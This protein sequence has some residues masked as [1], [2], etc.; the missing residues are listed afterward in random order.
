MSTPLEIELVEQAGDWSQF[1]AEALL[2]GLPAAVAAHERADGVVTVALADD[3]TL[4]DLNS[5]FRG[6]DRPTNVLSFPAAGIGVGGEDHHLG[7]VILARETLW[8]E[9]AEQ[10]KKPE[11]HFIHL[12]AHGILHVLGHDHIE[13]DEA[14]RM[15]AL[16]VAILAE[17]GVPDPYAETEAGA[18]FASSTRN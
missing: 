7:D 15:E 13:D 11:H 18:A 8:R 1:D 17:M 16:E 10:N 12:V 6:K 14:E 2:A 5:R 4:R 9:A 3:A